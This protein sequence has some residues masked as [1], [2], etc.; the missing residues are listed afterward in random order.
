MLTVVRGVWAWLFLPETS[1]RSLEGM[2]RLFTLWWW[3]I[4]R[5]GEAEADERERWEG[6]VEEVVGVI[7]VSGGEDEKKEPKE[8][9]RRVD[10]GSTV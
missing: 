8:S 1:G 7:R 5:V 9:A 6:K 4:G 2:D 3:E 10:T